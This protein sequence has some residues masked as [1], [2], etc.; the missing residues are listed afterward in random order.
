MKNSNGPRDK[1]ERELA[2]GMCEWGENDSDSG[3]IERSRRTAG[4]VFASAGSYELARKIAKNKQLSIEALCSGQALGLAFIEW[5]QTITA[6]AQPVN[7]NDE[8]LIYEKTRTGQWPRRVWDIMEKTLGQDHT[9]LRT[10]GAKLAKLKIGT[11]DPRQRHEQRHALG[12]LAKLAK[13]AETTWNALSETP[14]WMHPYLIADCQLRSKPCT[15]WAP[16]IAAK[17]TQ[18][19]IGNE[20][21]AMVDKLA[22]RWPWKSICPPFRAII[23]CARHAQ[24]IRTHLEWG[25]AVNVERNAQ[26]KGRQKHSQMAAAIAKTATT[27]TYELEQKL[28]E[29][30]D[31][32]LEGWIPHRARVQAARARFEKLW[33]RNMTSET[34][35]GEE[36]I[37]IEQRQT[38]ELAWIIP[39]TGGIRVLE[40]AVREAAEAGLV[41]RSDLGNSREQDWKRVTQDIAV[42]VRKVATS[43]RASVIP[44]SGGSTLRAWKDRRPSSID[45]GFALGARGKRA[46]QLWVETMDVTTAASVSNT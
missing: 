2:Q 39:C 17:A 46:M 45:H 37:R 32:I 35:A 24:S 22:R 9:A 40:A 10:L 11:G 30:A 18:Q 5:R 38:G 1:F 27:L 15:E 42:C 28:R 43:R 12:E 41:R 23:A 3:A 20:H 25:S 21:A 31:A 13:A 29:D 19:R 7:A 16:R 36:R 44:V 6:N 8:V 14:A 34:T 33:E 4:A 26:I